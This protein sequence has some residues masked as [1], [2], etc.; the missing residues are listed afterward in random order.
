MSV[1]ISSNEERA[2]GCRNNALDQNTMSCAVVSTQELQEFRD[3]THRFP[4]IS[5]ELASKN[6]ELERL[7]AHVS[8]RG[9]ITDV[10]GWSPEMEN[11]V[12]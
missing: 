2:C 7:S 3:D 1:V 9:K 8:V 10:V 11:H 4:E 12:E 6:V 5:V